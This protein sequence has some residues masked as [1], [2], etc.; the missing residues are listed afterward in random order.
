MALFRRPQPLPKSWQYTFHF[1]SQDARDTGRIKLATK[2]HHVGI[3]WRDGQYRVSIQTP[4]RLDIGR[5]TDL[6]SVSGAE[7]IEEKEL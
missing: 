2:L 6:Q 5:I 4:Y 7:W 1:E 3:P